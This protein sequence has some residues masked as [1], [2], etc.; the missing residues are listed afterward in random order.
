M[1]GTVLIVASGAFIGTSV[2]ALS[3]LALGEQSVTVSSAVH[4]VPIAILYDVMLAPLV[5]PLLLV[6]FRR[7]E[8]AERW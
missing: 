2:Y 3:G 1:L 7:L 4:V 5:V 8:P 6:A